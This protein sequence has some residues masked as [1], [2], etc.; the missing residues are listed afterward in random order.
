[1]LI[2]S[3]G[4]TFRPDFSDL[5]WGYYRHF[6]VDPENTRSQRFSRFADNVSG[7][8]GAGLQSSLNFR[9][10]NTVELKYLS[11]KEREKIDDSKPE[12]T[13][14]KLLDDLSLGASYNFA[15][16]SFRLSQIPITARTSIFNNKINIQGNA[17][18]DPYAS[19]ASGNRL[20]AYEYNVS[21]KLGTITSASL[22]IGLNLAPRNTDAEQAGKAKALA[23]AGQ[24]TR[25][26][27][28][29]GADNAPDELTAL[30]RFR[31]LYV[32]FDVPWTLGVNYNWSYAYNR[33]T[34]RS[35]VQTLSFNASV[36]LTQNWRIQAFS[37]Y[38]F[39]AKGVSI[40]TFSIFR[41]LHCWEL[42]LSATPFGIYRSY[43]LQ[44]YV[45][46]SM[47]Q[48]LKLQKRRDWQDFILG[49]VR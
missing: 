40:T 28:A 42:S 25:V 47:L 24:G 48:D 20:K 8:P 10:Q 12:F 43:F 9:L 16:D 15:A 18:L 38:D 3:A 26:K 7:G 14:L 30:E 5:S 13:Y 37:G 1:V 45:K 22:A 6:R 49:P 34:G 29:A 17:N 11:R 33:A 44:V 36:N 4:Y 39:Q 27:D 19:N 46:A 41:D 32:D 2:P 23:A 35:V 31:R 21:G